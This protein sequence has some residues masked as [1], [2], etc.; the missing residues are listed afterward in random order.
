MK[1]NT[2]LSLAVVAACPFLMAP[3]SVGGSLAGFSGGSSGGQTA[4]GWSVG[5]QGSGQSSAGSQGSQSG[6]HSGSQHSGQGAD[7]GGNQSANSSSQGSMNQDSMPQSRANAD[8]QHSGQSE[9]GSSSQS[10]SKGSTQGSSNQTSAAQ[11]EGHSSGPQSSQN[12]GQNAGQGTRQG[13]T[14]SWEGD[15][16]SQSNSTG[17]DGGDGFDGGSGSNGGNGSDGGS[18]S[19]GGGDYRPLD[20]NNDPQYD[21]DNSRDGQI[22]TGCADRGSKCAECVRRHEEAIQFNRNYLHIAWSIS[23]QTHEMANKALAFGDDVSSIHGTQG[24]AWQL[25]GRPQIEEAIANHR[26]VYAQKY[27]VYLGHIEDSL[28]RMAK[29]DADNFAV[30][31]LYSRYGFLYTEFIKSRYE[32][33]E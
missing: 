26:K 11:T 14:Q 10:G 9:G 20:P 30:S 17:S 28:A 18:G 24:L 2:A 16:G 22:P 29:C 4:S 6:S 27:R 19:N 25:G 15:G 31:D 8:A 23:K 1:L 13:P 3:T 33:A 5:G 21:P 32:S 7:H 12:S